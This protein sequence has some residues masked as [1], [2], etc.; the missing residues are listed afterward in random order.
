MKK[1]E[2]DVLN[3]NKVN[4]FILKKGKEIEILRQLLLEC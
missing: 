1:E 2:F 4:T 3:E